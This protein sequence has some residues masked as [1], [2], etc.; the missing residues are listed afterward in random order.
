MKLLNQIKF[1]S[2]LFAIVVTTAACQL[3]DESSQNP[4]GKN[5]LT[6][7]VDHLT[8]ANIALL[9]YWD[10]FDFTDTVNVKNPEIGEQ[11]LVDF[12]AAFPKVSDSV[13][14]QAIHTM[15]AKAEKTPASF[16][17]FTDQFEHYLYD[18]NSP[19]RN[20]LYF[21]SVLAFLVDSETLSEPERLGY[22]NLLKLVR[23]NQVGTDAADFRFLLPDG[24]NSSLYEVDAALTM[25]FFYEPGCSFCESS[26]DQLEASPFIKK[27]ISD[28]D[29]NIVA[30]YPYGDLDIWK[31][32][33]ERIPVNWVN[34]FDSRNQILER[35][36]Y[37]IRATPTIYLLDKDKKVLLKDTDLEQLANFLTIAQNHS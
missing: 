32:Y 3:A 6:S 11:K 14:R 31:G 33:Q 10:D 4:D 37:D 26:I 12:I 25:L 5:Q 28:Q 1:I 27:M 34:G 19:M 35:N 24:D 9:H 17:Y 16:N 36:L 20:D 2:F 29:L 7:R 30:I 21:E 13:R 15:L 8:D 22:N 23:K 18:P